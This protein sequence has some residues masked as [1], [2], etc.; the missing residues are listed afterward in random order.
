MNVK[1]L[2]KHHLEFLSLKVGCTGSYEST[3]VKTPHCWKSCATARGKM[4]TSALAICQYSPGKFSSGIFC[5]FFSF[6]AENGKFECS[7]LLVDFHFSSVFQSYS[8]IIFKPY[9]TYFAANS[10]EK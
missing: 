10:Y 2:T 9:P 6:H 8:K 1:L 4:W 7:N 3:L 5:L